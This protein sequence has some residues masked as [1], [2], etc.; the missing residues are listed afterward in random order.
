MGLPSLIGLFLD[1]IIR[2]KTV[3]RKYLSDIFFESENKRSEIM[4]GKLICLC[5]AS[6]LSMAVNVYAS[7]YQMGNWESSDSNDGWSAST[8]D[9]NGH[10]VLIPG[11]AE[12]VTLDSGALKLDIDLTQNGG[13]SWVLIVYVNAAQFQAHDTF[14]L[15]ITRLVSDWT[16]PGSGSYWNGFDLRANSDTTGLVDLGSQGWWSPSDGNG[17][18]TASWD[19]S[20][21]KAGVGSNPAYL[22]FVFAVNAQHY[23][24]TTGIFYLD[25]AR[26]VR[27][28]Q[29][30]AITIKKCTVTAGKTQGQDSNDISNIKDAFVASGTLSDFSPDLNDIGLFD[31]NIASVTSDGNVQIYHEINN[32]DVRDVNHGKFKYTHKIPKGGEGAITSLTFD[33]TKLTFAITAKDVNLT[34]LGCPLQLCIAL[35]DYLPSGEANEAIVNGPKKL[36]PTR[37]MR[38]YDD[39]LVVNKAKAKHNSTKASS[40]TLSVAGDIAVIDTDVNLCNEDVNFVWGAQMFS[41]PPGSF[42]ASKT[43]HLYK[44]SKVVADANG[45]PGV[46]T[47][48]VDTDKATFTLSVNGAN[49]IAT[50]G[51]IPFGISFADFNETVPVNSVTGRSW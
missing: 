32:F 3:N 12:G 9:P 27:T 42:K 24:N 15:D 1:I 16:P 48:Q 10:A 43:G 40:D 21:I 50:S 31:V 7:D 29:S 13:W 38:M 46:V 37:L 35:S 33:F 5:L 18:V 25:N 8:W 23:V 44:C 41:V 22:Q 28:P 17:P 51:S 2:I 11:V 36:I 14:K 6:M 49:A 4:C 47:A 45:E 30:A 26:L 20:S 19:Y 34:G 39:T